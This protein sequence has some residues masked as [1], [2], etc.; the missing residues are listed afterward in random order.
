MKANNIY[1]ILLLLAMV[2]LLASSCT[3]RIDIELDD[4]YTRLVVE[5]GI[6]DEPGPH[7]ISLSLSGSYYENAEPRMVE[8]ATVTISDGEN[9]FFLS[10]QEPGKYYTDAS[11][12]GVAG[13]T[14]SLQITDVEINGEV[15]EY[16]AECKLQQVA[17]ID[18]VGV[19]FEPSWEVWQV[20]L[21]ALDPPSRDFYMFR[22]FVNG[23][24]QTDTI[25]EYVVTADDFFNG[26]YTYGIMVQW[27]DEMNAGPGDTILLEM[28]RITEEYAEFIW[29][30]QE[31]SGY[32]TP[33][34]SGPPANIRSNISN[35][36]IGFFYASSVVRKA[37]IIRS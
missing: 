19:S 17:P 29:D 30:V 11:V 31:Q 37:T 7:V 4:T 23:V 15:E 10:E 18:S 25:D 5:G 22:T 1:R 36:A 35:G 6:T 33:M 27:V 32:N 24:L 34:F 12:S 13:K 9:I 26:N 8:G 28:S 14:Y 16:S 2:S 20:L 21:Y 3:E